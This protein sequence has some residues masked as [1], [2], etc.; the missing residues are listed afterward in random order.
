MW[1]YLITFGLQFGFVFLL[2]ASGSGLFFDN[3]WY[4]LWFVFLWDLLAVFAMWIFIGLLLVSSKLVNSL[5]SFDSPFHRL[6][7]LFIINLS[8]GLPT[9]LLLDTLIEGVY[10]SNLGVLMSFSFAMA[11]LQLTIDEVQ[12]FL[13]F[14]DKDLESMDIK[15]VD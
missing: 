2:Q 13:G 4:M 12:D 10:F 7:N 6:I 1:R 3:I 15:V 5:Q 14:I 8:I 9:I 11:L